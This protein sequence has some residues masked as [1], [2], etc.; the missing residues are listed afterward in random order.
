MTLPRETRTGAAHS[1]HED[2][3][4]EDPHDNLERELCGCD[5]GSPKRESPGNSFGGNQ[6]VVQVQLMGQRGVDA[7]GQP[8][9]VGVELT[10]DGSL[11]CQIG[12]TGF[13]G[14]L[15]NDNLTAEFRNGLLISAAFEGSGGW[16]QTG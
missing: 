6:G 5:D 13:T 2:Q 4:V 11:K 12:T 15:H 14:T 8:V 1:R 9:W 16:S 10:P 3:T 7:S